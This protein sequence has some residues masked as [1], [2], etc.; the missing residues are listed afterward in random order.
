M[1]VFTKLAFNI[2]KEIPIYI[3]IYIYIGYI[4]NGMNSELADINETCLIL[5]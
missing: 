1:C 3:Y 4:W 2:P 5:K